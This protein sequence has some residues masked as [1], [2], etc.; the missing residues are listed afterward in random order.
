MIGEALQSGKRSGT[1]GGRMFK[2]R[3]EGFAVL[4]LALATVGACMS[5]PAF[6]QGSGAVQ[7]TANQ[8]VVPDDY[9][10]FSVLYWLA[11]IVGPAIAAMWAVC[12]ALV[13]RL[14]DRLKE[15]QDEVEAERE[16]W[17]EEK[18]QL[19]A[20]W[21]EAKDSLIEAH[22]EEKK[23]LR[24]AFNDEKDSLREQ[25]SKDIEIL[26]EQVAALQVRLETE[27]KERR[28]ESEKLLREINQTTREVMEVVQIMTRSLDQNTTVIAEFNKEAGK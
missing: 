23:S 14:W 5:L 28:L 21:Q 15:V 16:G 10:P 1:K 17:Q 2:T 9:I 13:K 22:K 8:A 18:E 24:S 6:A 3:Q 19:V 20:A 26:R 7:E 12:L 27:Q 4:L 11:G 25:H